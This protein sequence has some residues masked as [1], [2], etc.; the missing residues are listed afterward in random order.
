M[1]EDPQSKEKFGS[2]QAAALYRAATA[3]DLE[4]ARQLIAQG[5]DLNAANAREMTLLETAMRD[6][7]RR[8]FDSLLDLGADPAYLGTHR[9]TP[10]HYAT[11]LRDPSWLKALLARGASTEVRNSMGD[12]LLFSALGADTEPH[13]QILLDAGADIHARNQSRETLLHQAASINRFGD[14]VRFLELGVDPTLKDDIGYTFQHAFFNTPERLL[15][16]QAKAARA[17][18]RA[19]LRSRNIPLEERQ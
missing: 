2:P 3:G 8:A 6:G 15:N 13:V 14:V 9:D 17:E 12:T 7:N 19:W 5:A 18:V 11:I 4:R 1:Q 10:L 16:P